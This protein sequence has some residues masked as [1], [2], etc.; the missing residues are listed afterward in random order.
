[1]L[2]GALGLLAAG[3]L[4]VAQTPLEPRGYVNDFAGVLSAET[5][6]RAGRLAAEVEQKTGAQLSVVIV[7]DLG[8][9]PVEDYANNLARRWGVGKKDNRGVLLLFALQ[10]RRT[11]LE[12]GYGLEPALPDGRAGGILR[13][14]R[15]AL[16]QGDYEQAVL[17]ALGQIAA[18]IAE[19]SGVTL[20]DPEARRRPPPQEDQGPAPLDLPWW[21]LAGGAVGVL[22][23]ASKLASRR[24]RGWADGAYDDPR[25][26]GGPTGWF[27]GGTVNRGSG[28]DGGGFGG[29]GGGDFGGG[30]A[31]SDW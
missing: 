2:A 26:F 18:V 28:W 23:V 24:R 17:L 7:Q 29:F 31:S 25:W 13:S 21:A 12:V 30:G 10:E 15:P 22:W 4:L 6:A 8:G 3:G 16:R 11:R 1:M 14:L 27:E 19:S 20:E 5:A 9:V